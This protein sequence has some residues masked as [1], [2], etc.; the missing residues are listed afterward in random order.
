MRTESFSPM[1]GN[2][3]I[4]GTFY[5]IGGVI[6]G[7][8]LLAS[9]IGLLSPVVYLA[10]LILSW[11]YWNRA[12]KADHHVLLP[13]T[14]LVAISVV[15]VVWERM[16][17]TLGFNHVLMLLVMVATFQSMLLSV[18]SWEHVSRVW[19]SVLVGLPALLL[20]VYAALRMCSLQINFGP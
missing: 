4:V 8:W 19:Y 12:L 13:A 1:A 7:I 18:K 14:A 6:V 2:P 9:G 10:S 20:F 5:S 16:I 15:G 17:S 11:V 3:S